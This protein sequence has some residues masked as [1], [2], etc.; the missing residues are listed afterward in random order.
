MTPEGAPIAGPVDDG[1]LRQCQRDVGLEVGPSS[2]CFFG[3]TAMGA[4]YD[5][6]EVVTRWHA[7]RRM[8]LL[9]RPSSS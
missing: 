8:R 3:R 1:T 4:E 2:Q 9:V 6:D 7:T 5:D